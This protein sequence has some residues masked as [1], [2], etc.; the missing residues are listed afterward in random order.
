MTLPQDA[1]P[2]TL[3]RRTLVGGAAAL[4]AAT[5]L[6]LA[7]GSAAQAA[8]TIRTDPFALGV[9]SGDPLPDSLL[10]WTRL[11]KDPSDATS[12]PDRDIPVAYEL[13]LDPRFRRVVRRGVAPARAR[14]AHSVHADVDCLEPG[15]EYYY[16]FRAGT[17][18][19]PTGLARTA[20]HPRSRPSGLRFAIANC[21]DLQN[22]YWPAYDAMADEDIDFIV[23]LGDYIYEYDPSSVYPDRRHTAP[24]TLGLGQLRTLS[25]YR[26]RHAQ[27]KLDPALQ[28]AHARAAFIATWDD[29]EVEN[30]YADDIDEIDDTG[31]KFQPPQQFLIERAA[32]YQ[33]YYEHMP[34]RA[35]YQP[36]S[37]ALQL[38]RRFDFGDLAR[39]SVLD[40]R[41][42]RTDQPG[43]FAGDFG[44]EAA[45]LGNATGN[46]TGARQEKWLRDNLDRSPARWNVIAQQVM[47]SRTRFPNF[48]PNVPVPF[49]TN[50]DQ[51]D[52]YAP[53]RAK[54]LQYLAAEAVSNPVVLSGD[55]HSTW[56]NDLVLNP[57]D[58]AAK[59]IASEF[60]STSISS[61]FPAAFDA[62]VKA[63][64]ATL[65]PRTRYFD[66]SRR[67]YL[68]VDVN[69][70]RWLTEARTVDSIATRTSPISTTARF[71]V[72]H[73]TPGIVPA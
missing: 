23:H 40:T 25:D 65:N 28:A 20:P 68:R 49:L 50:L 64:L 63:T 34:I 36:G 47:M 30:N 59:V 18:V 4:S 33:A 69:R 41:Q 22:G 19:S 14:F 15:Q 43:A 58:P 35:K 11:V 13:A 10:L 37:S 45:G 31:S 5:A 6:G 62:P 57:D 51:W 70:Q 26:A 32:G 27:Y 44:A 7:T 54:L 24:A 55:I 73:G 48:L 21:Q 42:Y 52:G 56:M 46:L 61:D 67:G 9:A 2:L 71:A 38:Y 17:Y 53:F 12:M 16:R 29:H 3:R 8:T 72:A 1:T 66:G 39:F 60:V